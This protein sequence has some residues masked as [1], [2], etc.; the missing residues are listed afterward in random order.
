MENNKRKILI[1]TILHSIINVYSQV[2]KRE[3]DKDDNFF[4]LGGHSLTATL[5]IGKLKTQYGFRHKN[6]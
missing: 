6:K 3:L 4:D 2:L 5:A 1:K